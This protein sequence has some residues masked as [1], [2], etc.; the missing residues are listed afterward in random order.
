MKYNFNAK[1]KWYVT[2]QFDQQQ[3]FDK[4]YAH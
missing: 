2:K 3:K 1:C 4:S